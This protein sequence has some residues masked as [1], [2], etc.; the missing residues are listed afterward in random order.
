V[1]IYTCGL[2]WL[3]VLVHLVGRG[4]GGRGVL[5]VGLYPF[6]LGDAL[7]IALAAILLPAGWKMIRY[8]GFEKGTR[9]R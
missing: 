7:K 9:M 4:L 6:L 8:F 1:A 2:A 5:A 3:S